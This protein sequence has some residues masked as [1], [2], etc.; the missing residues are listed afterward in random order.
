MSPD[1]GIA[2]ESV[3]SSLKYNQ[4]AVSALDL[5]MSKNTSDMRYL[6]VL[7]GLR[8]CVAFCDNDK[9]FDFTF[10][11]YITMLDE[12]SLHKP[13]SKLEK[14]VHELILK[15]FGRAVPRF[16]RLFDADVNGYEDFISILPVAYHHNVPLQ[17]L[18]DFFKRSF[19]GIVCPDRLQEFRDAALKRDYDTL[20]DLVVYAAFIDMAYRWKADRY[21]S[22]PPDNYQIVLKECADIP[23]L[24]GFRD[25]DFHE[26]NYY[27]T[28]VLLALNHYGQRRYTPSVTGD[29]IFF[30]LTG[31]YMT[32][33][34]RLDDIDLLCEYLYCLRQYGIKNAAFIVEGEQYII[35]KQRP[36]GGWGPADDPDDDPYD[37]LHPAWTAITLLVQGD[38]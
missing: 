12:I 16:S 5:E 11:N 24:Y 36:D 28:H 21:F 20:T 29:R 4:A 3:S 13:G 23:F 35:S 10:S 8:W 14:I 33:R 22:L 27:A 26:Q 2:G 38:D 18:K 34:N 37:K 1:A 32:V 30:Y 19:T 7:K 15:E 31:Q 17:P 25:D 6:S 9:N